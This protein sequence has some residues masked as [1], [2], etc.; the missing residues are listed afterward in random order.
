MNYRIER[1]SKTKIPLTTDFTD[2]TDERKPNSTIRA[3]REI[4]GPDLRG[5]NLRTQNCSVGRKSDDHRAQNAA[6][7][8][9]PKLCRL[10]EFGLNMK[11]CGRSGRK[12]PE[13]LIEEGGQGLGGSG[14]WSE[15]SG[16]LRPD[17]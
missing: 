1:R 6:R 2:G 10:F 7:D 16:E 4:R 17:H 12:I 5:S 15:N 13:H 8:H 3:I 11:T 14:Q 9:R